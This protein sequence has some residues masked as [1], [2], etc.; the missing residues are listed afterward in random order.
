M[1]K[2]PSISRNL[3]PVWQRHFGI[4]AIEPAKPVAKPLNAGEALIHAVQKLA[5]AHHKTQ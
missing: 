5:A 4:Q 3:H 2:P 1:N